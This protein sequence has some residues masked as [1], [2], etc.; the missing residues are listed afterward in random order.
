M[1]DSAEQRL[2]SLSGYLASDP[3]NLGLLVDAAEAAIEANKFNEA[4]AI[5]SHLRTIAPSASGGLYLSA[6]IEMNT[7]NFANAAGTLK[8]VIESDDAPNVRFN[9]AWCEA[10]L[11]NK[12]DAL[13]L[14]TGAVTSTIAA[15]AMLKTQILHEAGEFEHALSFGKDALSRFPE[16][17]GL[18]AAMA[19]LALD[20]EDLQL[21]RHCAA[22]GDTHP[23]A[24][25]AAGVID[26]HDGDPE[27]ARLQFEKSLAIRDHNP[28]AWIGRGLT[29]LAQSDPASAAS[30]LDRGAQ[31]FSSHVGSWI[32]AGWAHYLAG[33][34]DAAS[35]RFE[36][37]LAI[38]PNFCESHGSLA[39]I[40]VARGDLQLARRRMTTALKLDRQCF[41]AALA[42][43]LLSSDEPD[44][45]RQIVEAAFST[46]INDKG[47]T[48]A[49]YM[50][51]LS[52]PTVH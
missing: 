33:D 31:Q 3:D 40:G 46:P 47:M 12:P 39:V 16:D 19:T 52:R 37:A 18:L 23:E 36:R 48:I 29:S 5:V 21:A 8:T 51:G 17:R 34:I 9:L 28:R 15:A 20:M 32:A 25:A 35:D 1:N 24:L 27:R 49:S 30:D 13:E 14:L 43:V 42:Q 22:L 41:S 26:L 38:N 6:V 45:S 2:A 44:K 11:G 7:G 4:E 50:A 10:M